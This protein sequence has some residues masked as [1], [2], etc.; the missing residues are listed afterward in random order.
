[1]HATTLGA[2]EELSLGTS[3]RTVIVFSVIWQQSISPKSIE[4]QLC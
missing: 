1:M 4:K 3:D 2:L